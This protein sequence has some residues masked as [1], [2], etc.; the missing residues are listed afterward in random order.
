MML[1]GISGTPAI[2]DASKASA[3]QEKLDEDMNRFLTLLVAQLKNQDPLDPMDASEFTSQLV[4][5]ASVEQQ[6]AANA[7]L[8]KILNVQQ[9]SQVGDM[10]NFID[11]VIEAENK[12]F[13]LENSEAEFTYT[14]DA[15]SEKTTI[16]IKNE[17]GLTV[18]T[19]EAEKGAEKYNYVWDG[20]TTTGSAAPDGT[21]TAIVTAVDRAGDLIG[22][23]QTVFGRVTGAGAEDGIVSLFMGDV[24]VK[25]DKVLA[26]KESKKVEAVTP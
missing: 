13:T 15:K 1:G 17:K 25:M 21:Y 16:T 22:V 23:E 2:D 8:E 3:A 6:I 18:F 10:V 11:N 7:N 24:V 4:Q 20:R 5:F 19:T 12:E 9:T 14:L 26:V